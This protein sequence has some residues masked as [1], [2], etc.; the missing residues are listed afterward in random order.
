MV[1]FGQIIDIC[2]DF[3]GQNH[4]YKRQFL[5]SKSRSQDSFKYLA[6]MMQKSNMYGKFKNL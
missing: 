2:Q 5:G 4:V 3:E 6:A 1:I